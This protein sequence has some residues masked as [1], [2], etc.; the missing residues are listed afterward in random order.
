MPSSAPSG[1]WLPVAKADP[2]NVASVSF[3]NLGGY[4]ELRISL[5][6]ILPATNSVDLWLRTSVDNG[7]N[8]DAGA[9]DYTCTGFQNTA[10][11][12][13]VSGLANTTKMLLADT[14]GNAANRGVS[15]PEL[16]IQDFN[17]TAY[18][19]FSWRGQRIDT[20]GVLISM[21]GMNGYRAQATARNALQ[22][23]FSSGNI[24]S[25][26]IVVEGMV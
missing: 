15:I 16:R 18:A 25:G 11:S 5:A 9:A 10:G 23:L 24:A 20:G 19:R 4:R 8:Y 21:N 6:N 22:I 14:I 13:F 17:Q 3:T 7:A 2:S 1:L 12:S 26:H